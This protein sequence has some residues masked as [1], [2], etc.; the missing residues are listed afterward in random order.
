[1]K[2]KGNLYVVSTPIGNREDITLRALRVLRSVDMIAAEDTRHAGRLLAYHDIKANLI[3]CHEH[4][5]ED[6][7]SGLI[8]R[9][10]QGESVALISDAGTPSVSDP[11]YRLV[12]AAIANGI[13]VVPVPGVSA[14][15]AAI[16]VAG[17]PTD[18]FTF[19]GFPPR[20]AGKRLRQLECLANETR[21]LVFYESPRRILSFTEE[22]MQVMG[23]RHGVLAREMTKVHEEFLRGNLSVIRRTLKARPSIKGECTLLVAG[24]QKDEISMEVIRD[25]IERELGRGESGL[26]A[27]SKKIAGKYGLAKKTVYE[28][29]LRMKSGIN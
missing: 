23:D 9:L 10:E 15:I 6:R 29:A 4:N 11:G 12:K 17:M 24:Y 21:T 14:V 16:S 13:M 18:S 3:S 1:M 7:T 19:V 25:E 8:S 2:K 27:L 26:S 28:E 20:K 5:E 22:I